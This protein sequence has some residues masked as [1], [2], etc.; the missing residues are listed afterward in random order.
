[1]NGGGESSW[2]KDTFWSVQIR[3][4]YEL[5]VRNEEK[6]GIKDYKTERCHIP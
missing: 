1:M 6:K 2:I 3:L 5:S 4:A